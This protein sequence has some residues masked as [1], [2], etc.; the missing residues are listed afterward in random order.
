MVAR[1]LVS[2]VFRPEIKINVSCSTK[3]SMKFSQL[4]NDEHRQCL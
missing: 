2:H 3:L 1:S 4:I